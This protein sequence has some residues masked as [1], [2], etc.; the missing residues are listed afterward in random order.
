MAAHPVYPSTL[1]GLRLTNENNEMSIVFQNI[2]C[3]FRP[4]IA[5]VK[6]VVVFLVEVSSKDPRSGNSLKVRIP[7]EERVG[8]GRV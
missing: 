3:G 6:A 4:T 2:I 1:C 7:F 8:F 5:N